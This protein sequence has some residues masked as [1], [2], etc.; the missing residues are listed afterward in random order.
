M[1]SG[2]ECTFPRDLKLINSESCRICGRSDGDRW[3]DKCPAPRAKVWPRPQD[4][5]LQGATQQKGGGKGAK[6]K[7]GPAPTTTAP[8]PATPT[9]AQVKKA[10]AEALEAEAAAQKAKEEKA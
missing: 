3:S 8:T 10:A 7:E 4:K 9:K 2:G 6:G 5:G 1:Q